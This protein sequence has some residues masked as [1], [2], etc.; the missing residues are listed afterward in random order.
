LFPGGGGGGVAGAAGAAGGVP[1]GA[2]ATGGTGGGVT[3][4]VGLGVGCGVGFWK[5]FVADA[6]PWQQG[7][8]FCEQH[9]PGIE[10]QLQ[11]APWKSIEHNGAPWHCQLAASSFSFGAGI[12]SPSGWV[13][14]NQRALV[15]ERPLSSSS[16]CCTLS[17]ASVGLRIARAMYTSDFHAS[18]MGGFA[19]VSDFDKTSYC[20]F[21][22]AF[23]NS[24][25]LAGVKGIMLTQWMY[26]GKSPNHVKYDAFVEDTI[27][28]IL[29]CLKSSLYT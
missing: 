17:K 4:T 9:P 2:P 24:R 16:T 10:Q 25:L 19:L 22:Y 3:A 5:G 6:I 7:M 14:A 20:C 13:A 1:A 26:S 11:G 23:G 8:G 27:P 18:K 28:T 12:L 15:R 21:T 29:C